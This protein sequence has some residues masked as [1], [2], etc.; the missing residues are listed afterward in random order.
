MIKKQQTRLIDAP[1]YRLWQA[2]YLAFYSSRL[3]VDVAKRWRGY[4][5]L[6][7]LLMIGITMIPLSA[8]I[9]FDFN[10]YV[11]EQVLLPFKQIPPLYIQNGSVSFDQPM[12]YFIKNNAGHVVVIIDTTGKVTKINKV[13]PELTLLVTKHKL[14]SRSPIF[15]LFFMDLPIST[16]DSVHAYSF[17]PEDNEVFVSQEWITLSHILVIKWMVM[18]MV[19]PVMVL[20]FFGLFFTFMIVFVFLGQ[21]FAH[22]ILKF[23]IKFQAAC[24]MLL[25]SST[26]LFS[27]LFVLLSVNVVISGI[28]FFYVALLAAYFSHAVLALK[29][30]SNKMVFM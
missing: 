12:P 22:V 18:T 3:Y 5:F 25:V 20:F 30:A 9:I 13:Y 8:R 1:I 16:G 2:L 11:E 14:Y 6:Y 17:D 24:R 19:Y 29:R 28:G 15:H 21:V 7:F 26:P 23:D 10:Q 4:G 27:I